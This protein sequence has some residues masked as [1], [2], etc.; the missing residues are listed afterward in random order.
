MTASLLA[1]ELGAHGAVE[2]REAL[3]VL[4]VRDAAPFA[5]AAY[6]ARLLALA[7]AEGITHLALEL[8]DDDGD[9]PSLPRG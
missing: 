7:A 2:V 6:R 9:T 4:R 5:D 3:A 8:E 1:R